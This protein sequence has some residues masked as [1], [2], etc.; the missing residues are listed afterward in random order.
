MS[1]NKRLSSWVP[2][3][4]GSFMLLFRQPVTGLQIQDPITEGWKWV[5]P[6]DTTLTVNTWL[7]LLMGGYVRSTIHRVHVDRLGLLYFLRP[8]NDVELA[9]ILD[10]PVLHREG[11]TKNLFE[12]SRNPM[13]TME[14]WT[15]A[16][17]KWQRTGYLGP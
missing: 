4:T 13:P 9:T 6:Q 7:Q 2:G 3:H 16:K 15:F 17:Q 8:H 5:K 10:S 14:E 12:A 1:D 11:Y